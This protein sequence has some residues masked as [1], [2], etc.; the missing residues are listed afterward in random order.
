MKTKFYLRKSS[1]K[2]IINFEFRSGTKIKFRPSTGFKIN[3][4]KDWDSVK[5]RMKIPSA[6]FNANL[7]NS[8]LSEF[9]NLLSNLIYKKGELGVSLESV[10]SAFYSV[11]DL[12][13]KS[14]GK[15][16]ND[17]FKVELDAGNSSN[18]FLLYYEWFLDFYS[19]NNSPYSKKLLTKGTL[20]TL[21]S[22]MNVIKGFV[23]H[24][25]LKKLYFDDINR[26]FYNDFNNYLTNEKKYTKNYIGTVIQKLK[27]VMGY[28][29]EEGKHS[30]LEFRKNYFSKVT[31]VVSFPY[32][33][34]DELKKIESLVLFNE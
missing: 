27:T 6:N 25:N 17:C 1:E 2:S 7:I 3:N 13:G 11:F 31:E 16:Q 4:E 8:K 26:N 22:S 28:A 20:I 21:R 10:S 34:N 30:N 5:Q 15:F 14:N 9:D 12:D 32:L 33:N 29:Y 24:K 18:D 19:K 23:L